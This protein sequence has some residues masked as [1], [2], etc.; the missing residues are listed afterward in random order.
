VKT[1]IRRILES[2]R[3]L[4]GRIFQSEFAYSQNLGGEWIERTRRIFQRVWVLEAE[5]ERKTGSLGLWSDINRRS[6]RRSEAACEDPET[7][8]TFCF[9]SNNTGANGGSESG[10]KWCRRTR[11]FHSPAPGASGR[12]LQ[13]SFYQ[14]PAL[15]LVHS[16]GFAFFFFGG[17]GGVGGAFPSGFRFPLFSFVADLLSDLSSF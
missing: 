13:V 7:T 1:R 15:S 14:L 2:K 8:R 12:S 10:R 5:Y 17:G 16:Y 11:E 9:L 3:A 6:M 4:T